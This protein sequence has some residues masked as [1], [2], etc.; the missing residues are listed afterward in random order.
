[1]CGAQPRLDSTSQLRLKAMQ[2]LLLLVQTGL[3]F[4]APCF[5]PPTRLFQLLSSFLRRP[6]SL[7]S[8]PHLIPQRLTSFSSTPSRLFPPLFPSFSSTPRRLFP[9]L[10]S[11]PSAS[12]LRRAGWTE[13]VH[14]FFDRFESELAAKFN[15]HGWEVTTLP[16]AVGVEGRGFG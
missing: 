8:T 13:R 4:S 15:V 9:Q 7:S 14:L 10:L 3:S 2:L 5:S 1:M 11:S 16:F 12:P 6:S